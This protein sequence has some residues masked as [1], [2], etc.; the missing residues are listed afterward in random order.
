MDVEALNTVGELQEYNPKAGQGMDIVESVTRF[1]H[2]QQRT[3]FQLEIDE[4]MK[5]L[6]PLA[7]DSLPAI[8]AAARTLPVVWGPE[9]KFNTSLPCVTFG[10]YIRGHHSHLGSILQG[11]TG[12]ETLVRYSVFPYST[13]NPALQRD[14]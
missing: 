4:I 9:I 8:F 6:V 11:H 12:D 7:L 2:E 10:F 13:K 1:L 3:R 5:V 14:P